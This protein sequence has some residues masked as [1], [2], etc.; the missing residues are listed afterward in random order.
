[1]IAEAAL[2]SQA[3][4][5]HDEAQDRRDRPRDQDEDNG[6]NH[7]GQIQGDFVE[8]GVQERVDLRQ[9]ERLEGPDEGKDKDEREDAGGDPGGEPGADRY[10]LGPPRPLGYP[11]IQT[12][13]PQ[14]SRHDTR[15]NERN[16]PLHDEEEECDGPVGKADGSERYRRC[17]LNLRND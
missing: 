12:G 16:N 9:P 5:C 3:C 1:L 11:A 17:D 4:G 15:P 14:A 2:S 6:C 8:E 7:P 10:G 13:A